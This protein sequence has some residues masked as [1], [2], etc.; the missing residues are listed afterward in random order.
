MKK[1]FKKINSFLVGDENQ[2][3]KLLHKGVIIVVKFLIL[4]L[5]D[6]FKEIKNICK[7]TKRI[8]NQKTSEDLGLIEGVWI[9]IITLCILVALP[10]TNG[11]SWLKNKWL[12]L[13]IYLKN[14]QQ[15]KIKKIAA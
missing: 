4:P 2:D 9:L 14:Y 11:W 6:F 7:H 5:F 10:I 1:L 8:L 13:T 15:K 12:D 3:Q